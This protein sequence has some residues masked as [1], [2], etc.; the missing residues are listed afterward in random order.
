[1]C[2]IA[3]ALRHGPI[4]ANVILSITFLERR[5]NQ[6]G[7]M[8]LLTMPEAI[9]VAAGLIALVTAVILINELRNRRRNRD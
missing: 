2:Q 8:D 7:Q 5:S 9:A 3:T 4:E 6:R 1:M